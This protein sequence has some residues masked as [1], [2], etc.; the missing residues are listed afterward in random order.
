[1]TIIRMTSRNNYYVSTFGK[2]MWLTVR[3]VPFEHGGE[4][5]LLVLLMDT[6]ERKWAEAA[7]RQSEEKYRSLFESSAEAII[8]VEL[9]GTIMDCNEATAEI[10]GRLRDQMIGRRFMDIGGLDEKQLPGYLGLLVRVLDREVIA[11]LQLKIMRGDNEIRWIEVFAALLKKDNAAYAVQIIARDITERK[12]AEQVQSA[13][14]RISEAAQTAQNLD[15]LFTSIHVIIGELMPAKNFYISL[16]DASAD[17]FTIPYLADEFDTQWSPYKPG[18]GLGAYVLHTGKPLLATP[19]VF[20]QLEQSGQAELL[21]RRMVD[22]LGV[23][24]KTQYSIIGVMAVQT[25]DEAARLREADK[26]VLVFVSTQAAMAIERKRA[27]EEIRKLNAELEQRVAERTV[28][29][30]TANKEHSHTRFR[31]TCA[32]RCAP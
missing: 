21:G 7:L 14:Y 3:F 11:P 30:E 26:D 25:Y 31:T 5:H 8:M 4:P 15:E 18:K 28:Q 10:A 20:E 13:T 19:E 29:L 24:L 27:D 22:W 32:R 2:A 23:P 12:Q 9:D 17:L 6:S 1:M 16:Y